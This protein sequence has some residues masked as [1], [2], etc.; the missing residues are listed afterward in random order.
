MQRYYPYKHFPWTCTTNNSYKIQCRACTYTYYNSGLIA[1][2]CVHNHTV[3]CDA[4]Y[5]ITCTNCGKEAYVPRS[6]PQCVQEELFNKHKCV[7]LTFY[8]K[9]SEKSKIYVLLRKLRYSLMY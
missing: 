4:N 2:K 6:E 5:S 8:D 7:K 1:H 9:L 3:I